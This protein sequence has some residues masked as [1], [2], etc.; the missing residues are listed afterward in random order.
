MT[1]DHY[2]KYTKS[3]QLLGPPYRSWASIVGHLD[4]TGD[5]PIGGEKLLILTRS[6]GRCLYTGAWEEQHL[7]AHMGRPVQPKITEALMAT[8]WFPCPYIRN[9]SRHLNANALLRLLPSLPWSARGSSSAQCP[10][11][12]FIEGDIVHSLH[13]FL[14]PRSKRAKKKNPKSPWIWLPRS[15]ASAPTTEGPP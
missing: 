3:N 14:Q 11:H 15:R 6:F 1:L 12:D 4:S 9:K 2:A 8:R 10:N 7:D 13:T 5:T